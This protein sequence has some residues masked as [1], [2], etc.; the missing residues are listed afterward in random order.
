[1]VERE[2]LS[3]EHS[4]CL[5]EGHPSVCRELWVDLRL[6]HAEHA[7]LGLQTGEEVQQ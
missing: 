6:W 3:L 5:E 7:A 2:K 4:G 1:M